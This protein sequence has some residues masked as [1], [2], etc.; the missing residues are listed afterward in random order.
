MNEWHRLH[1]KTM[2][3]YNSLAFI[4]ES[5]IYGNIKKKESNS[6]Q[7]ENVW[8]VYGMSIGFEN[9]IHKF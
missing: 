4:I 5:F 3:L 8:V 1:I 6:Q 2:Q 7:W 9:F